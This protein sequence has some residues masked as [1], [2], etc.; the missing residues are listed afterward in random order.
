MIVCSC[1][2][3]S[4]ADIAAVLVEILHEPEAPLPTPGLVYKRLA[5]K[6]TCCACAPVAVST[7]YEKIDELARLGM[8]APYA[9]TQAQDR[10]LRA[11]GAPARRLIGRHTVRPGRG[12]SGAQASEL[13]RDDLA[14]AGS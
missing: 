7:I 1:A 5:K 6:M 13:V 10:I 8:V 9:C 4:D 11:A 12:D 3:I 2:V 14:P